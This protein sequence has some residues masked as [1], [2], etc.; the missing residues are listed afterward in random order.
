MGITKLGLSITN[1]KNE[2]NYQ[3]LTF[4]IDSAAMYSVV[5]EAVLE[6]LNIKVQRKE[7]FSLMDGSVVER[8][9]GELRFQYKNRK[10]TAPVIFGKDKDL[11]ILGITALEVMGYGLN[12][13]EGKLT[14]L[15]LTW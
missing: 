9:L 6:K 13:L 12:P 8:A 7:K 10:G 2:L 1:P 5:P 14:E 15:K 4:L 11:T 3:H